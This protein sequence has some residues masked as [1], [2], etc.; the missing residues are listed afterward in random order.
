MRLSETGVFLRT[1]RGSLF[2]GAFRR[3]Q[4][5]KKPAQGNGHFFGMENNHGRNVAGIRRKVFQ[6]DI[7][8]RKEE[9][10]PER[11]KS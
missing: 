11:D 5:N 6:E 7:E 9:F 10:P 3:G 4:V 1:S 8:G 2:F